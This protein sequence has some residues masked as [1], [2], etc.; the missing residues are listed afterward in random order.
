VRR[1]SLRR[2]AAAFGIP[3]KRLTWSVVPPALATPLLR[4][5]RV[6]SQLRQLARGL[7][8]VSVLALCGLAVARMDWRLVIATLA[9]ARI[10]YFAVALLLSLGLVFLR[11][12]RWRL[13]LPGARL[14][15]QP[16]FL[17]LLVAF[18]LTMVTPAGLPEAM[19]VYLL[20]ERHGV[21]AP[22]GIASILLEK[23]FEGVGMIVLIA[24]LPF[25]LSLPTAMSALI[26]ALSAGGILA[27]GA[28]VWLTYTSARHTGWVF[29]SSLWQRIEPGLDCLRQPRTFTLLCVA[30]VAIHVVD[31]CCAWFMLRSVAIDAP[32]AATALL[33]LTFS[34]A[35][36][37][38][39]VPGHVGMLEASAV[40]ALRVVGVANEPALA[41]A[42][43]C[44][45][46]QM[47]YV[48]CVLPGFA[49]L[50]HASA[51]GRVAAPDARV[52][53][54]IAALRKG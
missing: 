48:L 43:L 49:L 6:L 21:P 51:A 18:G 42:V 14:P 22:T 7:V 4:G 9:T 45:A 23:L 24:P 2:T 1:S 31:C 34:I 35:L 30:S 10:S 37:I 8:A 20:R 40:A 17:Y 36:V 52:V 39:L 44:H 5:W 32:A 13:L 26:A 28:V 38:P 47:V 27:T 41:F 11:A 15:R 3:E 19:R 33:L 16:L 50:R 29:R 12:E 46:G 53:R 25:L 54:N